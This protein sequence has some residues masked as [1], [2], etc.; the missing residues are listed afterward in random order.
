MGTVLL[1]IGCLYE[2]TRSNPVAYY[3][4]HD[5]KTIGE[6]SMTLSVIFISGGIVLSSMDVIPSNKE[7]IPLETL[8]I[9]FAVGEITKE[10]YELATKNFEDQH[11]P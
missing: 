9:R 5:L 3:F 2:E 6:I 1:I 7:K 8:K 4:W 10:Q 11:K